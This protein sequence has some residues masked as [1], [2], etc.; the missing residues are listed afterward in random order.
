M[1]QSVL[2]Y[3]TI[4]FYSSILNKH[5]SDFKK[6]LIFNR[7]NLNIQANYSYRMVRLGHNPMLKQDHLE[8]AAQN[9]GPKL[10]CSLSGRP[11]L[12]AEMLFKVD[13]VP[14]KYPTKHAPW[15]QTPE[16]NHQYFP[17]EWKDKGK[18]TIQAQV[19]SSCSDSQFAQTP[20]RKFQLDKI[21]QQERQ[22]TFSLPHTILSI[23]ELC[24]ILVPSVFKPEPS[25]VSVYLFYQPQLKV[26]WYRLL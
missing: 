25:G 11:S 10:R 12:L 7:G 15:A 22:K 13:P 4:V 16:S 20:T 8:L 18:K 23:R 21:K 3:P 2:K 19:Q 6:L 24:V 17:L 26:L 1:H 9:N 5:L 14:S